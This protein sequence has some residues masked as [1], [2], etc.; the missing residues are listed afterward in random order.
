M[1]ANV[2][3]AAGRVGSRALLYGK[4]YLPEILTYSGV[5]GF[6]GSVIMSCKATTKSE[7]ILA[8]QDEKLAKN[9]E[10]LERTDGKFE[11][12]TEEDKKKDDRIIRNRTRWK[13]AKTW[14]PAIT[15]LIVSVFLVLAGH[16]VLH[17]RSAGYAAAYKATETAYR[18][19]R[20]AVREKYGE[21]AC[22][23]LVS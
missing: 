1:F 8:E 20:K 12:Y 16:H 2:I 18:T 9:E 13:L 19:Y 5:A 14:I 22:L 7:E 11:S 3:A 10:C 21:E 15:L 4:K 23:E 17:A 6:I